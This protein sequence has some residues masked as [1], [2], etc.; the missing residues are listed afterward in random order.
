[1]EDSFHTTLFFVIAV[2]SIIAYALQN[3]LLASVYRKHDRLSMVAYRGLSL[4][5]TMAPLLLFVRFREQPELAP[6]LSLIF[7][8]AIAA[9]LANWAMANAYNALPVGIATAVA[10]SL[11]TVVVVLLGYF[12]FDEGFSFSQLGLMAL[13]L[14][15]VFVLGITKST[16]SLPKE[17]H[18][19]RGVL[20]CLFFGIVIGIAF[21]VV[22]VASRRYHPF[23]VGYLWESTI[24][25][26]AMLLAIFRGYFGKRGFERLSGRDF[27]RV[28]LYSSPT[29]I[30]TGAFAMAITMGPI[31]IVS[32]IAATSMVFGS[33]FARVLYDEKLTPFQWTVMILVC[34]VVASLRLFSV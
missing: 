27:I 8:A 18:L 20:N 22:G 1:M 13:I 32:A 31:G 26:I 11:A 6:V 28:A 9:A 2:L 33:I 5:I 30:G 23:V 34:L 15:G 3:S 14:F 12:A 10:M 19:L 16:G 4:G 7:A 17:Y 29:V 24:G 25:V 21:V